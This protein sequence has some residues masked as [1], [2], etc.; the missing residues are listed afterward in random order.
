MTHTQSQKEEIYVLC[1]PLLTT[2]KTQ[3]FHIIRRRHTQLFVYAIHIVSF[4]VGAQSLES[5]FVVMP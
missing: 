1:T 3:L 2:C 4:S 5:D